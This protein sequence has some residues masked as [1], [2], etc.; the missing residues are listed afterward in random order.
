MCFVFTLV[1][2][3][4][5]TPTGQPPTLGRSLSQVSTADSTADGVVAMETDMPLSQERKPS[6]LSGAMV[7]D[8][9]KPP[10]TPTSM[11]IPQLSSG[12]YMYTVLV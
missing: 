1:K 6:L 2:T 12:M 9:K 10:L 3:E 4:V 11:G 5:Q 7:T 8:V